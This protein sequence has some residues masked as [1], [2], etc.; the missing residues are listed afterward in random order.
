MTEQTQTPTQLHTIET[1]DTLYKGLY[2]ELTVAGKQVR[3]VQ[4]GFKDMFKEFKLLDRQNKQKK[5]RP[6]VP[7]T[8]SKDLENFLSV[9]HGT[10]LTKAQVMKTISSYIKEKNLQVQENKRQFIPNKELSKIFKLKKPH[11]M[12]FVEINKH[13]SHH[14]SKIDA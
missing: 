8:L 4:D 9:E 10:K 11:S 7:L 2:D 6:Q 12:T 3:T 14:L 5:K 1:L 13:V